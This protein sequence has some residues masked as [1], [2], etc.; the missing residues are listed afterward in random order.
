[1]Y[2]IVILTRAR[3]LTRNMIGYNNIIH[4]RIDEKKS[5]LDCFADVSVLTNSLI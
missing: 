2:E 5:I 1:M 4:N 3:S